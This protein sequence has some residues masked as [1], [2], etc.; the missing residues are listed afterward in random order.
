MRLFLRP[1]APLKRGSRPRHRPR[2]A[3][4]AA[5]WNH[6]HNLLVRVDGAHLRSHATIDA[7]CLELEPL[8][9]TLAVVVH[10][11]DA[12]P[13]DRDGRDTLSRNCQLAPGDHSMF[14]RA[15][16]VDVLDPGVRAQHRASTGHVQRVPPP[17]QSAGDRAALEA[18]AEM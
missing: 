12:A 17:H 14:Q 8:A 11:Q 6:R 4:R 13:S 9:D 18:M 16:E 7:L 5:K 3:G 15:R 1:G 10:V 2:D